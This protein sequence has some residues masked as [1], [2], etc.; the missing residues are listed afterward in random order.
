M[1][2]EEEQEVVEKE[3]EEEEEEVV[4]FRLLVQHQGWSPHSGCREYWQA[5]LIEFVIPSTST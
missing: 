4:T 2:K 3:E 5:K 1:G